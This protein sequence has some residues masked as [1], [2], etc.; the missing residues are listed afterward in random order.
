MREGGRQDH[1]QTVKQIKYDTENSDQVQSLQQTDNS[2]VKEVRSVGRE[3]G[4][5]LS[6]AVVAVAI[7][8]PEGGG[9]AGGRA[10]LC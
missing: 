9:G 7:N 6:P 4:D 5:S 3:W 2:A 8:E 1:Q 10:G